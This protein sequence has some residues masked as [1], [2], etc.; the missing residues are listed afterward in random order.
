LKNLYEAAGL[1]RIWMKHQRDYEQRLAKLHE[2]VSQMILKTDLYLKL[3]LSSYLGRSFV[4]YIEPMGAPGQV[5]ARSYGSDYYLVVSPNS[6]GTLKMDQIRHTYLHYI[7]DTFALK[8]ANAIKRLNPLLPLVR[9]AP[10]DDSYKNDTALMV[11]ECLIRAIED[12]TLPVQ[13]GVDAKSR[14]AA[15]SA[16]AD[17]DMKQGFILTRYFY[18]AL[19]KFEQSPTGLKDSFSDMLYEINLDAEKKRVEGINFSTN[20]APELLRASNSNRPQMLDLAEQKLASGDAVGAHRIAQ[21]ALDSHSGDPARAMFILARTATLNKDIDGAQTLFERTLEIAREPR[22]VAWS[23]IYLGRILDLRCNR[24]SA[25]THYR[26]ALNAGDPTPDIK[27]AA[28]KGINELPPGCD[29]ED[30]N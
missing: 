22:T 5:N 29:K 19:V 13:A 17:D 11:T 20:A 25:L 12:R 28:D 10:L 21:E 26:A 14:E 7:L 2:P 24:E 9:T 23:H 3:Q 27:S 30:K 1:H 4:V 18:D 15:R 8:R 6:A 16:A